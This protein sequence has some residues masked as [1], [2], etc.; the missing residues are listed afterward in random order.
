MKKILFISALLT[1]VLLL[2]SCNHE[3]D[4][5]GLD[6]A[7][8]IKLVKNYSATFTGT[9]P[10]AG[11]FSA[12]SEVEG[13]VKTWLTKNYY[14][15]DSGSTAKVTV[16]FAD[17]VPAPTVTKSYT[18]LTADYDAMGTTS[19]TPG[20]YDN[21]DATMDLNLYLTNYLKIKFPYTAAKTVIN[22][23]YQYYDAST[24][25][26]STKNK[27]YL[28]DG[29]VW[30]EAVA[31]T[32]ISDKVADFEYQ[33]ATKGWVMTMLIGGVERY[34]FVT[35]DYQLL[36]DWVKANKDPLYISNQAATAATDEYYFGASAKYNNINNKV[37]TWKSYYNVNNEYDGKTDDEINT[38]MQTR[39]AQGIK[40]IVLPAR[41]ASPE[42]GTSYI[43]SYVLY[44]STVPGTYYMSF[45]WNATDGFY[46][47]SGPALL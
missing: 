24:K 41:Y 19:G 40:D 45:M 21:F 36:Y 26:T 12:K 15:C 32:V 44:G 11:Y 30:S 18:L 17:V 10:T 38:L 25:V 42:E 28:Y 33:G 35:A 23:S 13:A 14:S 37:S 43:V 3:S 2:G 20:K 5:P 34:T 1:S 22:V 8:Q 39:L 9:Y 47:I 6:E 27:A 31:T 4:F 7:T 16:K 46:K 29:S